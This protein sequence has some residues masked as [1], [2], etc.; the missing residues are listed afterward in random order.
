V[1]TFPCTYL[2]LPLHYKKLSRAFLQPLVQKIGNRLPS[3]KRIFFS[4]PGREMLVKSVLS[5]IPVHYL[6]VF[7]MP[8]G[9]IKDIDK[10][11]RGFLWRGSD[12]ENVK[13][14]GGGGGHCLVNWKT[15]LRPKA[16]GG[17][18]IKDLECFN[19][20]LRLKWFW[21]NWDPQDRQWKKL[22]HLRDPTDRS[23]FFTSTRV[24]VGNGKN[25][26]FWE[27]KWLQGAAKDMAP[28]LFR[29]TRF[30]HRSVS[31]ELKN[32]SW[33]RSLGHINTPDLMEEFVMLYL[34]LALVQ[35]SDQNGSI[36]WIWT[37]VENSVLPR[38]TN[39]SSWGLWLPSRPSIFGRQLLSPNASSLP[40]WFC[41]IELSQ[42]IIWPKGIGIAIL[43]A[44][45]V[46]VCRKLPVIF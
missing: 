31:Q 23:L 28:G 16:M 10:F 20:A 34:A 43:F 8:K 27:S 13:G 9:I 2:G 26:P 32:N 42:Q 40:G 33:I 3:W 14:G 11:R 21:H 46:S 25:T 19:R 6:T 30:K 41:T 45:S 7:K 39:A 29:G 38:L 1:A 12:S 5:A 15:C 36:S 35:L 18:G 4:Y 17:L 24:Q 44:L 22:L 37:P